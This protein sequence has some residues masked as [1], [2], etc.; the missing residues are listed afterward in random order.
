[1]RKLA[2]IL[3][4][5]GIVGNL[6]GQTRDYLRVKY[7]NPDLIV[8]LGVGLWGA[9]I[10]MDYD[11]DGL[12]DLLMSCPDIP[13]RGLY[14]FKNI[15]TKENPLFDQPTRLVE[16]AFEYTQASIVNNTVYVISAGIEY[17]D[18]KNNLFNNPVIITPN[19]LPENDVEEPR[20]NMWSYVDYDSDGD[21]DIL[22]GIDDQKDYHTGNGF[23][24]SGE[25][26]NG[27]LRGYMYFLEN[28]NGSYIN[29]GKILAGNNPIETYGAPGANMADFDGD[30]KADIIAG[31]FLD[32]L[33]WFKNIGTSSIPEFAAGSVL[34][35]EN[36]DTIRLHVQMIIPVAVDFNEDGKIDLLVADEDGRVVFIKNTG[37]VQ[38]NAP[39][40]ETP[41]YL[42][43]KAGYLKFGALSAPFSVDWDGNGTQD[44]ICGS[45]SGNIAFIKN[46][47]TGAN[48]KW[49]EPVLMK[50]NGEPIR[51]MA[52]ENGSIHGP[53]E[54]KW[55]YTTLSVADWDGDGK[56]DLIVNSIFGEI[57]W[58]KNTGD[59]LELE[60][61]YKV[62]VDWDN[63]IPQKPSW[64][65]WNPGETDLVTQWRT[66][67]V[68][69]D[70]NKD[71]LMDLIMIDHEGYLSYYERFI[72][73]GELWL[74][75]G[76]RIFYMLG[77]TTKFD[78]NNRNLGKEEHCLLQ[79][80]A[81][82]GS[83][84]RSGRRKFCIVDWN[85]DG[86]LD[87]IVNS[88]NATLFQNLKTERGK[89]FF[90]NKGELVPNKLAGHD[91][92]PT[93]V[94]WNN[95]GIYDVVVGAEDGHFYLIK[96][97]NE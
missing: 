54:A 92:C 9:P 24:A 71:G 20:S 66:I 40:F 28:V 34:K 6:F 39:V 87:I 82:A 51:F 1:M 31:E 14:F 84:S 90:V 29:R 19:V 26:T 57:V 77:E 5:L 2:I 58:F 88:N 97:N 25:W 47:N 63:E 22:V 46:L 60:G 38:N 32:K 93:S 79:L 4:I 56:K 17:T 67:P 49:A 72:K 30:G 13:Y 59:L 64:N 15:G 81:M 42:K 11:N 43:Q 33:T 96:N 74:K 36:G 53:A 80:N 94:D 8:D 50:V 45:S 83:G 18:F 55:G 52:G 7:N 44:L 85:N 35:D 62:K 78:H 61:P 65:W 48:P 37:Q 27:P 3:L 89:T 41:V 76:Q 21:L 68:A 91:T 12:M 10:P 95:D 23:N 86:K 69:I 70:W 73:N 75:P 16:K